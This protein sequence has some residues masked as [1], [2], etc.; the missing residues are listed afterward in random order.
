MDAVPKY[1]F[2]VHRGAVI[3]YARIAGNNFRRNI[4]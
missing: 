2:M 3:Y 1:T 4:G